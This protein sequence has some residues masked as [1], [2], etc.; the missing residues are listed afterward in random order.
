MGAWALLWLMALLPAGSLRRFLLTVCLIAFC[1]SALS[2]T[3]SL[4][5]EHLAKEALHAQK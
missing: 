1:A 4:A 3:V 5:S 2:V